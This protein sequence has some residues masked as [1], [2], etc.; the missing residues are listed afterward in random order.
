MPR[1]FTGKPRAFAKSCLIVLRS[2]SAKRNM[3]TILGLDE[4]SELG[5][6]LLQDGS[7]QFGQV[8]TEAAI[9]NQVDGR[10]WQII[11]P[12]RGD[13]DIDP[14][15]QQTKPVKRIWTRTAQL[16]D[17]FKVKKQLQKHMNE[18]GLSSNQQMKSRLLKLTEED[19]SAAPEDQV[20]LHTVFSLIQVYLRVTNK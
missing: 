6:I 17:R 2:I 19:K 8:G 10:D 16:K 18:A 1:Q 4:A 15:D 9:R 11:G 14:R 3:E 13:S 7:N 20:A 5:Q 12:Y